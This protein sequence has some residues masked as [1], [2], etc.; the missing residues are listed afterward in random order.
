VC[1]A[2]YSWHQRRVIIKTSESSDTRMSRVSVTATKIGASTVLVRTRKVMCDHVDDLT[3]VKG[4][5]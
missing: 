1:R 5:V 3:V 4:G 2:K